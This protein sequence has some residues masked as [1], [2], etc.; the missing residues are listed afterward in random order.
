MSLDQS[1]KKLVSVI[2]YKLSFLG[3]NII[4]MFSIS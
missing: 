3:V 1:I 4:N 2:I